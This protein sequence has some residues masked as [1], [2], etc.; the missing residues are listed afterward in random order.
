[1]GRGTG[2]VG[3]C[4]LTS[5]SL[6]PIIPAPF[7]EL[8]LFKLGIHFLLKD[9]Q[10]DTSLYLKLCYCE[11]AQNRVGSWCVTR[12]Q[13]LLGICNG[14][15]MTAGPGKGMRETAS[16]W[17][18]PKIEHMRVEGFVAIYLNSIG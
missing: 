1:M 14:T 11:R 9:H 4:H 15:E 10:P 5:Y 2:E 12:F 16:E 13:V 18:A 3:V 8:S 17:R 6:D 7:E